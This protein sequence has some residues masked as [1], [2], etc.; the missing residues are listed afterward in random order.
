MSSFSVEL[1]LSERVSQCLKQ[2][3]PEASVSCVQVDQRLPTVVILRM[4][5]ILAAFAFGK[6]DASY[7]ALYAAFKTHFKSRGQEWNSLDVAFVYCL[8]PSAPPTQSFCSQIETDVYFCRKFVVPLEADVATSLLRLPFFPLSPLQDAP[9]RPPSAQT[10]LQRS[11]VR[12]EL[13]RSLVVPY[14]RGA[15]SIVTDCLEKKFGDPHGLGHPVQHA[16]E[17]RDRSDSSPA[18]L[19]SLTINNFR[20]YRKSRTFEFGSAVTVLYGPNG[21]GKTSFFDALD[22]VVTGG[23]GRLK[24][25]STD[26]ALVKAAKHL[27]SADEESV[28]SLQFKRADKT[29][30]VTRYLAKSSQAT[31]DDRL[32][33]SRKDVL[34]LLTGC[35]EAPASD[36]V[37]NL[38]S[39]FRAT[40]LFSQDS[41]E[42]TKDFP[43]KSELSADLVSRML[44]FDDYV[45]GMNKISEVQRI[46]DAVIKDANV[47]IQRLEALVAKDGQELAR[48]EEISA[49]SA[50]PSAIE[51][52]LAALR[53]DVSKL[54]VDVH[55][56]AAPIDVAVVRG[57]RAQLESRIADVDL[58]GK[59]LSAAAGDLQRL[60]RLQQEMVTVQASLRPCEDSLR[61]ADRQ[62]G[63]TEIAYRAAGQ[64]LS[65]AKG[66]EAEA[67]RLM[68]S[69]A[70]VMEAKPEYERLAQKRDSL[71]K[72]LQEIT[73]RD[74]QLQSQK[75]SVEFTR[76]SLETVLHT[77][78]QQFG[79][80]TERLQALEA[81]SRR[82]TD[83][84]GANARLRD[85]GEAEKVLVIAVSAARGRIESASTELA[86]KRAELA[87]LDAQIAALEAESTE[88]RSLLAQ[89][90]GHVTEGTCLLC[91]VDHGSKD[92]LLAKIDQRL[93]KEG[94][95]SEVRARAVQKR[96]EIARATENEDAH[97]V[98]L[99]SALSQHSA[100]RLEREKLEK[101]VAEFSQRATSL[102]LA[103]PLDELDL[104]VQHARG[105]L[106]QLGSDRDAATQAKDLAVRTYDAAAAAVSESASA[107]AAAKMALDG[108]KQP[109]DRLLADARRGSMRIDIAR[110]ELQVRMTQASASLEATKSATQKAQL[111]TDQ[112]R[113]DLE[114]KVAEC[115]A[116]R[117]TIEGS[118]GRVGALTR[119]IIDIVAS[120]DRFDLN[121][122]ST[123]DV[124]TG[125]ISAN[126]AK[127]A[128]V[129]ATKDRV[130]SL[131]VALDAATTSA[132]LEAL[133]RTVNQNIALI[134][135]A[136]LERERHEPWVK[137]FRGIET[138]LDKQRNSATDNFTREYGP[139]TAVIQRRLRPVYGFGD[140]EV[141]SREGAITVGVFR[142]GEALRPADYFSQSQVQTLL[143]GL[144]LT[145]SSSQT[146]SAFSSVM[147]DDPV[148]HF[149]DLNTYALL[150]LI[151]GLLQSPDGSRQFVISTCDE[152][153]LQ[154]ARQKF[155]H[156]N[157]GAKFYRFSAIGAEGPLVSEIPG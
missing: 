154:L 151:S 75:S 67:Q 68:D 148:T 94:P 12:A 50:N 16:Q 146:W 123:D 140:V 21:F 3:L 122:D 45:R 2:A 43:D 149:D 7:S 138:L 59:H 46:L 78:L 61:E 10:L 143:L 56:D 105:A 41:Q 73:E 96:V 147:M 130:A 132:A 112:I 30:T 63:T 35:G 100:L 153:L 152:K 26:Q 144:F 69:L 66:T 82:K 11:G 32:G 74:I 137:Y 17:G 84:D 89:L 57:W 101:L 118:H 88:V 60:R 106:A 155:R 80:Q 129:H 22:F 102:G 90:R 81:L 126:S 36:R 42:L 64:N 76:Q 44:A 131:E 19:Q 110:H 4:N 79:V 127:Q 58:L 28:V 87:A 5:Q 114:R 40:H 37:D 141:S 15:Q 124:V 55:E 8:P 134:N 13:A 92:G 157:G 27:D 150:D 52:E 14:A 20:A 83:V 97:R 18:T 121:A 103:S 54:G 108:T 107:I 93:R 71:T 120:L 95:L 70:W 25:A 111:Q 49:V 48:L 39:L 77:L 86:L 9:L 142:N 24:S 125:L 47:D 72:T 128:R 29:H 113:G 139:R 51:A 91:G 99:E 156:L 31:L 116:L 133:R 135:K 117:K 62:R 1:D 85:L 23:V 115:V 53:Q 119:E 136:R 33:V 38:I 65:L 145:A 6:D 109:L 104:A 98:A 34:T